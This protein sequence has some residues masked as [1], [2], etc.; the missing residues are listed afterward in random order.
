MVVL[1]GISVICVQ[2]STVIS[3]VEVYVVIKPPSDDRRPT[4]LRLSSQYL[5][6]ICV[7]LYLAAN[8]INYGFY[9]VY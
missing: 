6:T 5:T 8:F 9:F 2:S 7:C 1:Y 3:H 4:T